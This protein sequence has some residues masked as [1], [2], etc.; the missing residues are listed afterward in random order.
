MVK[1]TFS[2]FLRLLYEQNRRSVPCSRGQR[3]FSSRLSDTWGHF[4]C[5]SIRAARGSSISASSTEHHFP[6]SLTRFRLPHELWCNKTPL[7]DRISKISTTMRLLIQ[8]FQWEQSP[9]PWSAFKSARKHTRLT[10]K[11]ISG[12]LLRRINSSSRCR[13]LFL[14]LVY[15]LIISIGEK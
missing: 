1:E 10:R 14:L 9:A 8:S 11:T 4:C 15:I 13:L 12:F 6:F 2:G 3:P 5:A 7:E